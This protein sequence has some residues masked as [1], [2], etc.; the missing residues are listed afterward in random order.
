MTQAG[1]GHRR[2]VRPDS[3]GGCGHSRPSHPGGGESGGNPVLERAR[4][5]CPP[6]PGRQHDQC[7]HSPGGSG[8]G[9]PPV[10]RRRRPD[11]G[12]PAGGRG[13]GEAS[14]PAQRPGVAPAG[15][16]K[17][18]PHRRHQRRAHRRRPGGRPGVLTACPQDA[19]K[20]A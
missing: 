9:A 20:S 13:N 15:E 8:G 7:R 1:S 10:H 5:L 19:K 2:P 6:G 14:V 17:L 4:L 12:S 11:C 16:R 18:C 3:R